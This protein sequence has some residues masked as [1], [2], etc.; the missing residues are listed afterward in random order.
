MTSALAA[1]PAVRAVGLALIWFVL[2]G[3]VAGAVVGV[4][5]AALRSASAELRYVVA[6]VGLG[7]MAVMPVA[8]AARRGT[9]TPVTAFVVVTPGTSAGATIQPAAQHGCQT[10]PRAGGARLLPLTA[11]RRS[12]CSAGRPRVLVLTV[13]L[14]GGWVHIVRIRRRAHGRRTCVSG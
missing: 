5:L 10:R 7:T 4:L 2:Q 9:P 1:N 3:A 8:T 11:W 14:L 6:C 13:Q 12:S